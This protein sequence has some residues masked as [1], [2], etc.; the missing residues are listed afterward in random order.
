LIPDWAKAYHPADPASL[1]IK[2]DWPWHNKNAEWIS[3][4]YEKIVLGK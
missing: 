2:V 3:K 1:S 4:S